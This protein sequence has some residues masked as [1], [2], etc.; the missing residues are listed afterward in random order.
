M[1]TQCSRSIRRAPL[2]SQKTNGE[3]ATFSSQLPLQ[4]VLRGSAVAGDRVEREFSREGV[5]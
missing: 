1:R 5:G 4:A 2:Y 3:Y